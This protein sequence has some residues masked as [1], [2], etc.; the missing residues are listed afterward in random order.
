MM[1]VSIG[2]PPE[3][4]FDQPLGLLSDCHRRIEHFLRVLCKIN[5]TAGEG[6]LNDEHQR[7]AEAAITYFQTA[8]PRHTADEEESLFPLLRASQRPEAQQALAM[9]Q[10][11]HHDH[12]A[13]E[14]A[15]EQINILYREWINQGSLAQSDRAEL[16]QLL[17][18]LQ[19]MYQRHLAIEDTEL[20]PLAAQALN[21][22]N[23]RQLGQEMAQRRGLNAPEFTHQQGAS[24]MTIQHTIDVRSIPGPQRHPLIFQTFETLA[25]GEALELINDHDPFPLHNQFNFMKRGQ[26]AWEYLQQGPNLW[27]VQI[28]RIAPQKA[29]A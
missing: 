23:L 28:S 7:A 12:N 8:G 17:K 20:F 15:H 22:Q 19:A 4:R 10:S 6:P 29:R 25:P 9:V 2:T 13:A 3:H 21:E 11:L 18:G 27:R 1:Y 14:P 26:F 5:Q 16:G 24:D